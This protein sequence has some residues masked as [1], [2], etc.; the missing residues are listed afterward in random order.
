MA[1]SPYDRVLSVT[2]L[3]LGAAVRAI[4][5]LEQQGGIGAVVR[6]VEADLRGKS[7]SEVPVDT[8]LGE[9]LLR[10]SL[11]IKA[12]VGDFN[13]LI[14]AAGILAAL[15]VVLQPDER[16]ESLSLGAGPTGAP[17]LVTS[18]RVAE[19]KFNVWRGQDGARQKALVPDVIRL[20]HDTSGRERYL[21][22]ADT[23]RPLRWLSTTSTTLVTLLRGTR[24]NAMLTELAVRYGEG[25]TVSQFWRK[26]RNSIHVVNLSDVHPIFRPVPRVLPEDTEPQV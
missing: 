1:P 9:E 23:E 16:I 10:G 17:D 5:I 26:V 25:A 15:K 18:A 19:F 24:H 20:A 12:A 11:A 4:Q 14:H 8:A 3:D 7:L 21:Y 13:A 22:L 2:P 6:S